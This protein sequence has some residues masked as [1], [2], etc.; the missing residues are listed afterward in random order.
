MMVCENS[1]GFFRKRSL[2]DLDTYKAPE[3]C[4]VRF[5]RIETMGEFFA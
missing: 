2:K 1:C 4:Q 3:G 5:P